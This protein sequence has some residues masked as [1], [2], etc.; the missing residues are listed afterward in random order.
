MPANSKKQAV[1]QDIKNNFHNSKAV[2]F[3][4]F[5]QVEN[6]EISQLRKRLKKEMGSE[7]KVY[8]NSL[9]EK[10][11]TDY[12]LQLKQANAFIFCQEDEYKPLSIL[13]QFSKQNSEIKRFQGGIYEQKLI[14]SEIIEKWANL[15][16]KEVLIST[17][18]YYLN[19]QTQ[20]LINVLEKLK[21]SKI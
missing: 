10:A 8:K 17:L 18:C 12:S 15:P 7:L 5:H 9:V 11:L 1:V 16:S 14:S 21:D 19:Y 13:A 2:I 6:R 4:N 3:Y 20:R